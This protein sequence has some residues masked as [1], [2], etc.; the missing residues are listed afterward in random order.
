M[1]TYKVTLQIR[2]NADFIFEVDANI[3]PRAI[4]LAKE[5]AKEKLG[6]SIYIYSATAIEVKQVIDITS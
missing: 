4:H 3:K 1:N 5:A 6:R 2:G